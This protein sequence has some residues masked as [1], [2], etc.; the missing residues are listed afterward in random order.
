M[1]PE[2]GTLSRALYGP[3]K[4]IQYIGRKSEEGKSEEECHCWRGVHFLDP[5][6]CSNWPSGFQ[7]M[8]CLHPRRDTVAC[9]YYSVTFLSAQ[10]H[11]LKNPLKPQG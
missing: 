11:R 8:G 6:H 7:C 5:R 9:S 4:F 10:T 1:G 2:N 3:A